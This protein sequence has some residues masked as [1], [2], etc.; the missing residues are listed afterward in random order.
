VNLVSN[1]S[2]HLIIYHS[3]ARAQLIFK[4]G[5]IPQPAIIELRNAVLAEAN[6]SSKSYVASASFLIIFPRLMS[7]LVL[8]LSVINH[9]VKHKSNPN[10]LTTILS[11]VRDAAGPARGLGRDHL[12]RMRKT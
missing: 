7:F 4:A 5:N 8:S 6:T 12:R 2:A 1:I 3:L 11:G 10:R 9:N